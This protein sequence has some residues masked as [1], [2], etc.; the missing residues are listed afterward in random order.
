MDKMALK[1][2]HPPLQALP[3]FTR[4]GIFG[5]KIYHLAALM[6]SRAKSKSI[7]NQKS[8]KSVFDGNLLG[9]GFRGETVKVISKNHR[10]PF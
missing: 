4:T 7:S 6:E 2:Q 9:V 3:K 8:K 1:Y 10:S 5:L